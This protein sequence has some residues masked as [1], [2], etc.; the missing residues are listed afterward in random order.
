[1][2]RTDDFRRAYQAK[3]SAADQWL[4]VFGY[5]NGFGYPRLGLSVSRKVGNAIERNR[6]KRLIREAFRL[7]RS[8]L[9]EGIDLVVIPRKPIRPELE[10]LLQS[11]PRLARRVARKA[12]KLP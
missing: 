12:E 8:S 6:W 2:R 4:L 11:L 9:P 3:C 1:M 7:S 10:P 5:P